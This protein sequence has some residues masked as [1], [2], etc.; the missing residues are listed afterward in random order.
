MAHYSSII[1]LDISLYINFKIDFQQVISFIILICL[2]KDL[3][4]NQLPNKRL[5]SNCL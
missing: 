1:I 4:L 2:F 5:Q 3:I